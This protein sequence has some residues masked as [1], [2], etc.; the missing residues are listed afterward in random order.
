MSV[1]LSARPIS[2]EKATAELFGPGL[3]G[4]VIFAGR[5]RADPSRAGRVVALD[6]EVHRAPALQRL[7]RIATIA[8]RRFGARRVVLWHRVGLVPVGEVSVIAGAAC[9]HR[10]RAFAAARYLIEELKVTVPIW[11]TDRARRGRRP[12]PRP[13]RAGER[14]AG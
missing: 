13:R 10:A 3:G 4:V 8:R 12:R 7:E 1:R 9:P 5:V 2:V 11:K 6:Y 14:S